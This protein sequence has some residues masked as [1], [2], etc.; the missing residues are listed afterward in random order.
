MNKPKNVMVQVARMNR[1]TRQFDEIIIHINE[2]NLKDRNSARCPE[3]QERVNL[4]L[5]GDKHYEH[6][7]RAGKTCSFKSV[8]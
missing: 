6:K 1:E 3:C 8:L 5:T 2:C 4:M 7:S